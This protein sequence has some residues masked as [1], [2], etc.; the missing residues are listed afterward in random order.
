M[1]PTNKAKA[2]GVSASSFFDLKAELAKHEAEFKKNKAAGKAA[3]LVGGLARPDKKPTVW[4]RS[5]K[6]VH[7]RATRDIEL[8]EISK[9]TVESARAVLERKAKI[10]DK[11]RKGKS[12]G[13]NDKQYDALL[14]DFDQKDLGDSYESD[15]DDVDE[16][17]TI[18][19]QSNADDPI[20]EYEDEFG[21]IRT[22]RRSE[23]PRHLLPSENAELNPDDDER[24]PVNFFPVYEPSAERIEAVQE[25]F[26][27]ANNPLNVHYDASNEVRAK[28]AGFY[29]FSGDEETR[30][31]QMEELK[32]AR[33]ETEKTRQ[34]MGATNLRPGEVEG[35]REGESGSKTGVQSRAMEKRKRE[36]EERR[37]LLDAKRRKLKVA[38][39]APPAIDASQSD[40]KQRI[41]SSVNTSKVPSSDP[42]ASIE[43]QAT[44][45][46]PK[47]KGKEKVRSVPQNAADA[48]LARLELDMLQGK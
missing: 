2:S 6:G 46:S 14:V 23:I 16:S 15:S 37:K 28:G 35:M 19:T 43:K 11:L 26:S 34:E 32:S 47:G 44:I 20:I 39:E 3:E 17:L 45:P 24:N 22:G 38:D 18:P 1:A 30:K 31:Q 13:L 41:P 27:D 12:G 42:F 33:V 21:R 4:A 40:G 36:I 25:A 5:N 8:E 9:V 7:T 48:F 10:Y 29:Q